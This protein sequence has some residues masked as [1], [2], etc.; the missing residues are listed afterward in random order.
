[1][2]L[3][4][5][6]KQDDLAA[7]HR[8]MRQT[9]LATLVT[10]G[11]TGLEASHLPVLLDESDGPSGTI[12]G[13][14]ARANPQWRRTTA[15]TPALAI[16]P[17]PDAYVSPAWYPTKQE[18]G[19]VVPTW[20]YVAVHAYGPIEFF[21][22]PA[23]L[24]DIVTALTQRHEGRRAERPSVQP[25]AVSDAPPDYIASQ[26][27]GIVGFRLAIERLE[28]K[29]KLSQNREARDAAG[30]VAGLS[31]SRDAREREVAEHVAARLAMRRHSEPD[32]GTPN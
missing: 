1:M 25:W 3:P 16:F 24:L 2:Y 9:R 30:V 5:H 27:K 18:T 4:P 11:E 14:L 15:A 12:C 17:G 23:R 31:A 13:H 29:W 32:P 10:L 20:N 8:A 7:L 28:G 21:E 22:D 19:K 26:L 6:F